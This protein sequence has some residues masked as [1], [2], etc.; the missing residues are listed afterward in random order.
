MPA[1]STIPFLCCY[2]VYYCATVLLAVHNGVW[3]GIYSNQSEL[4]CRYYHC[5]DNDHDQHPSK[6]DTTQDPLCQSHRHVPYGLLRLCVLGLVGVR[7]CQLHLLRERPTDAEEA[8]RE[9]REGKQ[10]PHE[11]RR[12]P[13]KACSI[14]S[15]VSV[16]D[17][18]S[19]SYSLLENVYC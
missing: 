6:R 10:W 14:L 16:L 3:D 1:H 4:S 17:L 7:V 15:N 2:C 11:I 5:A 13:G 18:N 8:R 9:S 19:I 12:Q